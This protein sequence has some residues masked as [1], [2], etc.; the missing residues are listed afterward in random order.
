MRRLLRGV[1]AALAAAGIVAAGVVVAPSAAHAA[2]TAR[3]VIAEFGYQ[4]GWRV[5]RHERVAADITGDRRA[6]IVGFGDAGVWTAVAAGGG[7]FNSPR[8]VIADFG[9][10]TG[11]RVPRHARFVVDI[12][13]DGRADIVGVGEYVTYSALSRGDGTFEPMRVAMTGFNA[14]SVPF[15]Y[16]AEDVNADRR[17]DLIWI[18]DGIVAIALSNGDG[19]FAAPYA[20][21]Y[22]FGATQFAAT[23]VVHLDTD[24]VAE[25][26]AMRDNGGF[27]D[28]PLVVARQGPNGRFL[29]SE[30]TGASGYFDAIA[31]VNGDGFADLV[32]YSLYA[33]DGTYVALG[34]GAG[35]FA[36]Y[37]KA[38]SYFAYNQGW[39]S[40]RPRTL[41]NLSSD[42]RADLVGFGYSGVVTSFGQAN[43]TFAPARLAIADFGQQT[44]WRVDRHVRILADITA[45]NRADI[46]AFG[47]AGV[48]V[49]VAAPDG[50]FL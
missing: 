49:A 23:R 34:M 41:A 1:R 43:G 36:N 42:N 11:W 14:A 30:P 15:T 40:D 29:P 20:A 38:I 7:N 50:T 32:A 13:G 47:D 22:E 19:T 24:R 27:H 12:S 39:N 48:W 33:N 25:V 5:E 46:V 16:Y 21:T 4:S 44:G 17:A 26:L 2:G 18:S 45:D 35:T 28:A 6:D 10:N 31:D 3:F 8:F 37:T 9:Y